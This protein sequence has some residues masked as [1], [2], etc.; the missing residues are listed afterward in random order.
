GVPYR[1]MM[2]DII[3]P[4]GVKNILPALVNETIALLKESALVS[5]IG[6]ADILQNANV[7]RG[8]TFRYLE[9]YIIAGVLYYV[10]VM[11]LTWVARFVER[12]MRR[13]D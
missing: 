4:Q 12:R 1:R 7:V 2:L 3:L 8:V 10:M 5:T 6:L 9:P 13:S 11:L